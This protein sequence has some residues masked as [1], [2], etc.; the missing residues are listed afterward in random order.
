[1]PKPTLAETSLPVLGTSGSLPDW[2][3]PASR[4]HV[5]PSQWSPLLRVACETGG[6]ELAAWGMGSGQTWR[7]RNVSVGKALAESGNR[8]GTGSDLGPPVPV[9]P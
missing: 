3:K 9:L 8:K 2:P 6:Q 5:V 1:M 7:C 4:T